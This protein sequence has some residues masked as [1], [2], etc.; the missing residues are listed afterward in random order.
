MHNVLIRSILTLMLIMKRYMKV[1]R[2][3]KL[4][5]A[6]LCAVQRGEYFVEIKDANDQNAVYNFIN[7]SGT[8]F[9]CAPVSDGGETSY[10]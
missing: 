2:I 3:E 1:L 9:T 7:S 8:F 10:V 5:D 6:A 4:D